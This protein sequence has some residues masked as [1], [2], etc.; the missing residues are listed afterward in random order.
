MSRKGCP[1]GF[2]DQLPLSSTSMICEVLVDRESIDDFSGMRGFG[3]C[4][5]EPQPDV[6]FL[7]G[8]NHSARGIPF[9]GIHEKRHWKSSS[10]I[11]TDSAF[12][13][14]D[15]AQNLYQH[16]VP[17]TR[18]PFPNLHSL[19][20][21]EQG[22]PPRSSPANSKRSSRADPQK[23][24]YQCAP[25]RPS[26]LSSQA[27]TRKCRSKNIYFLSSPYT[28][29]APIF[30]FSLFTS[31]PHD[32]SWIMFTGSHESLK[33]EFESEWRIACLTY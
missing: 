16:L 24:C 13:Q 7:F 32:Q 15:I 2:C 10:G 6:V 20:F 26:T 9:P 22:R 12:I 5:W 27:P 31:S 14:A 23:D 17:G 28:P 19:G 11:M 29:A 21:I 33:Q 25:F 18:T 8:C 3:G 4:R 1:P 30:C